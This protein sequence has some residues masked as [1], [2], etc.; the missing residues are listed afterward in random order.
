MTRQ[1]ATITTQLGTLQSIVATLPTSTALECRLA[2]INA[3]LRDLSQRVSAAPS[4][5]A[6]APTQLPVPL[7]STTT[8]PMQAP[9][10]PTVPRPVQPHT[11][12]LHHRCPGPMPAHLP[13]V[14]APRPVSTRTFPGRTLTL[15]P[16][17]ATPGRT[18]TN[19]PIY[20]KPTH[21]VREGTPTPPLSSL[22]T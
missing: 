2:P 3:S 6:P 12:P 5:Q 21:F 20:G 7:T 1:L 4:T 13:L 14:R 19:F 11:L 17:M 9:T 8:R 16:F 10:W 15:A 18:R 22:G